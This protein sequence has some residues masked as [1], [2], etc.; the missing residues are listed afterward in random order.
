VW[1]TWENLNALVEILFLE[2]KQVLFVQRVGQPRVLL[3][4]TTNSFKAKGNAFLSETLW[5]TNRLVKFKG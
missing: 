1:S 2:L 4:V 3:N 5:K